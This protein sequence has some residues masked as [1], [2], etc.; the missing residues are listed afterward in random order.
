MTPKHIW[1]VSFIDQ[2][3]APPDRHAR[4]TATFTSEQ[5]AKQF[6]KKLAG[7]PRIERLSAGTIN[8]H[9]P[10]RVVG[11]GEISRWLGEI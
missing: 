4:R 1:Y 3:D 7:D 5:D 11:S 10:K 2:R 9:Q 6:A 8:P